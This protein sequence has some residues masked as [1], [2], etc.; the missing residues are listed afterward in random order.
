MQ[1][2][3][4]LFINLIQ[5]YCELLKHANDEIMIANEFSK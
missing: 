3:Q 2:K 5:L 1:S 4:D